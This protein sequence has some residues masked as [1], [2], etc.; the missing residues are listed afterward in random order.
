MADSKGTAPTSSTSAKTDKAKTTRPGTSAGAKPWKPPRGYWHRPAQF[1]GVSLGAKSFSISV[2]VA[3]NHDV[4]DRGADLNELR[5]MMCKSRLAVVIRS[6]AEGQD[7]PDGQATFVDTV[8][9]V[10]A[11]AEVTRF[12]VGMDDIALRLNFAEADVC[13]DTLAAHRFRR[14]N[15]AFKRTGAAVGVD[16][17]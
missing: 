13:A 16:G 5:K 14:G 7:E 1:G 2:K 3:L 17:E 4:P 12:S 8:E 15:V 6:D 11:I 10:A 9:E